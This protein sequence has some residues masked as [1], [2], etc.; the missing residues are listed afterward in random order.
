M[1]EEYPPSTSVKLNMPRFS[2]DLNMP[3]LIHTASIRQ[4]KDF[5]QGSWHGHP[6]AQTRTS[7]MESGI[8]S[9]P[10]SARVTWHLQTLM[11]FRIFSM[12]FSPQ[13]PSIDVLTSNPLMF[14]A[15]RNAT[16]V[17]RPCDSSSTDA[18]SQSCSE[19]GIHVT[20][21]NVRRRFG[22]HFLLQILTQRHCNFCNSEPEDDYS[23]V[24]HRPVNR[25]S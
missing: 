22:I 7:W 20:W 23:S 18:W 5:H 14:F 15:T 17:T 21:Q 16:E 19:F 1:K 10:P 24:F 3:C 6:L 4:A 9:W 8:T 25:F 13:N 2:Q 12:V 11:S